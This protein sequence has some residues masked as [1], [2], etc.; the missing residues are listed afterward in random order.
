MRWIPENI[1]C[2]PE[3]A[4]ALQ[5]VQERQRAADDHLGRGDDPL[6]CFPVCSCAAREQ[7]RSKM[8]F[9]EQR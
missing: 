1:W 6:E 8:P 9:M 3:A 4:R 2:P 7:C 5:V